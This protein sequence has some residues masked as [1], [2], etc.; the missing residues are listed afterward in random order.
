MA[1][2][3][4]SVIKISE[5]RDAIYPVGSIY[6]SINNTNPKTFFGG[7]WE[8]LPEGYA[9]WTC[10][11]NGG[12]TISAGLPNIKGT[13]SV[14][15]YG[16]RYFGGFGDTGGAFSNDETPIYT[17]SGRSGPTSYSNMGSTLT[18]SAQSTNS[19]TANIY[20]DD[21]TTVQPPAYKVYAWRRKE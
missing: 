18:F 7:E 14:N 12:S 8:L 17:A 2:S 21:C 3:E 1:F 16:N 10:S 5:L 4:N 19:T 6:L 15:I 11:S 20:K 9:L 13:V